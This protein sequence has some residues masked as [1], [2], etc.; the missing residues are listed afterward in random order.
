MKYHISFSISIARRYPLATGI[1]LAMMAPKAR[2][3]RQ[4]S[5]KKA[6]IEFE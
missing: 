5:P 1:G 2:S 6:L 4:G 3:E